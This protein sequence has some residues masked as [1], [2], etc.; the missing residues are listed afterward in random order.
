MIHNRMSQQHQDVSTLDVFN[1]NHL[2]IYRL[3]ESWN[4]A[5]KTAKTECASKQRRENTATVSN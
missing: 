3:K 5:Q 4:G 2:V 1:Q